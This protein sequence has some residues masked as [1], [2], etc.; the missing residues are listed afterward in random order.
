MG[1]SRQEYRSGLPLPS[2]GNRTAHTSPT[3][4]HTQ[5]RT[6]QARASVVLRLK[7]LHQQ[8]GTM[9]C[10]GLRP[11]ASSTD[12]AWEPQAFCPSL[13]LQ[14]NAPAVYHSPWTSSAKSFL[15]FQVA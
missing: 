4:I 6:T 11:E 10:S 13:G 5:Q 2:P 9:G 3:H 14:S 15:K 12:T 1:F 8:E 7:N